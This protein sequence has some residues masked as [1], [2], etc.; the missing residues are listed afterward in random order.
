MVAPKVT[1]P[2]PQ[3]KTHKTILSI[4][5]QNPGPPTPPPRAELLRA[6]EPSPSN[7]YTDAEGTT[8]ALNIT[9]NEGEDNEY[10][11]S[12]PSAAAVTYTNEAGLE[13]MHMFFHMA[14]FDTGSWAWGHYVVEWAT[15]GVFQVK[16]AVKLAP[17]G[18]ARCLGR[19][20]SAYPGGREGTGFG[21]E[22][23]SQFVLTS[24]AW[25]C[26]RGAV[27]PDR[28]PSRWVRLS[29]CSVLSYGIDRR[30]VR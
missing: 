18:A 9:Y 11:H 2:I 15:K 4:H 22:S 24:F 10:V 19:Q 3:P 27:L 16:R 1:P 20:F 25:P 5:S 23:A 30:R 14:W 28:P 26:D 21:Q 29:W 12:Y 7:S 17:E 13:E 8:L 6:N